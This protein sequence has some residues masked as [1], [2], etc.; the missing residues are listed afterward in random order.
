MTMLAKGVV[1]A[2]WSLQQGPSELGRSYPASLSV[3]AIRRRPR[4]SGR[5][6]SSDF[7]SGRGSPTMNCVISDIPNHFFLIFTQAKTCGPAAVMRHGC[8]PA[9]ACNSTWIQLR[10]HNTLTSTKNISGS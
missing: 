1:L 8:E 10:V 5:R 2:S 3:I 4:A 6:E 7:I 9:W